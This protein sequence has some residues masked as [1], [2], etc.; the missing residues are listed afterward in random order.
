MNMR[1]KIFEDIFCRG[2]CWISVPGSMLFGYRQ[3]QPGQNIKKNLSCNHMSNSSPISNRDVFET[4]TPSCACV[5]CKCTPQHN[6]KSKPSAVWVM[7][8]PRTLDT[9]S[10]EWKMI[11]NCWLRQ[12]A[13]LTLLAFS[14]FQ[15]A[16]FSN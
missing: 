5:I 13:S 10:W 6:M 1:S 7:L 4:P 14:R 16:R 2:C 11:L 12:T 3:N 9:P 8:A 15:I